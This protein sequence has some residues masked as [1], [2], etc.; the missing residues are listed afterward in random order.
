MPQPSSVK[1][2][3]T[4]TRTP[5][6]TRPRRLILGRG[7]LRI[8]NVG[9]THSVSPFAAVTGRCFTLRGCAGR[10]GSPGPIV[11]LRF[12][13]VQAVYSCPPGARARGGSPAAG[14]RG[15]GRERVVHGG[16][17]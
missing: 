11:T 5:T 7:L 2:R 1:R 3:N 12:D 14:K 13:A 8:T 15:H 6:V 16:H 9:S 17:L 4:P 10:P